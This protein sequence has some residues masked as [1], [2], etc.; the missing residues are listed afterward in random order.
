M[1][2]LFKKQSDCIG[3]LKKKLHWV[4]DVAF[5]ED[6]SRKRVGNAAQNFSILGKIVLNMLKKDTQKRH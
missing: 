6:A 2:K 5:S 1:P 3:Q 4:L